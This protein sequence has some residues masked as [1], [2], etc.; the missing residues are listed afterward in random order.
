MKRNWRKTLSGPGSLFDTSVW[1]ALTFAAH[2]LHAPAKSAFLAASPASG[3]LFCRATQ[4]SFLRLVSTPA[5]ARAYG[6]PTPSNHD[7]LAILDGLM[8]SAS[9]GFVDEPPNVFPR[10][11]T[12]ADVASSS[13]KRWMDAYLAAFAMEAGIG[14]V[15]CDNDFNAFAGLSAT[16]LSHPP[17]VP[18][19]SAQGGAGA[20]P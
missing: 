8:T 14:L 19:P 10:W 11:R 3:A 17:T 16:V 5:I 20:A 2:P 1:I 15:T 12:F 6:V 13:P 18:P 9:V 7:A 4:Q